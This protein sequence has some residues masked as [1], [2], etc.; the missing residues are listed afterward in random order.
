MGWSQREI[1]EHHFTGQ[2]T[3]DWARYR[4]KKLSWLAG[5]RLRRRRRNRKFSLLRGDSLGCA[6]LPGTLTEGGK[7]AESGAQPDWTRKDTHNYALEKSTAE[8]FKNY[9]I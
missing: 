3:R 2:F 6:A 1:S 5:V 8:E 7:I 4:R 9:N